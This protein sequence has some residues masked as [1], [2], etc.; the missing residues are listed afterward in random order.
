V[1]RKRMIDPN[2]WQSEDV[3]KLTVFARYFFIGMMSNADD[4]GKGIANA[5][6]LKSII[7]PYDDM[8]V[9]EVDKALSEIS[10]NTSVQIYVF[11]GKRYYKFNNW[12]KWQKVDHPI[13]SIIPDPEK[14]QEELPKTDVSET[15]ANASRETREE[16][17]TIEFNLIKDNLKE[18]KGSNSACTCEDNPQKRFFDTHTDIKLETLPPNITDIDFDLLA[19]K[20][21]QSKVLKQRTSFSWLCKEWAKIKEGYYD[22]FKKALEPPKTEHTAEEDKIIYQGVTRI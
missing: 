9:A 19:E 8:R 21:K 11:K 20:I 22:D 6:Y 5:N 15:L 10:H 4:E 14:I 3:S 13:K 2:F 18:F 12:S 1:A 16:L 17:R 7:F